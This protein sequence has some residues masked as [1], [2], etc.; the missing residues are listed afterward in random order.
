VRRVFIRSQYPYASAGAAVPPLGKRRSSCAE[1][2]ER[3][4]TILKDCLTRLGY[5]ILEQRESPE[6]PDIP[7][8][9]QLRVY[10]HKTRRDVRGDLFY[11]QMHLP[12]LFTI[13]SAGWGADHS[14]MQAC[15]SFGDVDV[16]AAEEFVHT[17]RRRFLET[18]RSKHPQP[19]RGSL[20]S[21][22][23]DY[24]FVP[25]QTPRDYV[26]LHHAPITVKDFIHLVARW[27]DASG[28]DIVFKLHPGLF[29][30]LDD[31]IVAAAHQCARESGRVFCLDGNVHDLIT[32]SRGVFTIN[33]GVGFESLIHGKPVA[34]FGNCDYKW[35]TFRAT[36]TNLQQARRFVFGYTEEQ[37]REAWKFI[38]YYCLHHTLSVGEGEI[39]Q[40]RA[41]LLEYLSLAVGR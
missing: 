20:D 40:S 3:F 32:N 35:V 27:A 28:Q 7:H 8:D 29:A 9:A 37:R 39:A 17:Q 31:E 16:S 36:T 14:R 19:A 34:T 11:K 5:E 22:P 33:S 25:L 6:V 23:D 24:I 2:W 13:D 10:A 12:E 26:Q 30:G 18:G 15:P 1:H 4:E 41:R 38:Y 21:F